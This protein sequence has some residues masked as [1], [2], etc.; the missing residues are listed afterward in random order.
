M[1]A[2]VELCVNELVKLKERVQIRGRKPFRPEGKS[3]SKSTT[4][5]EEEKKIEME[6]TLSEVTVCL[7]MDR[8]AP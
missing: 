3:K 7:L 5:L 6:S 4:E 8:F 2:M 1:S